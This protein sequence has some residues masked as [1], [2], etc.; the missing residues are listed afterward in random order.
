MEFKA[1]TQFTFVGSAFGVV[2]DEGAMP[3]PIFR[4]LSVILLIWFINCIGKITARHTAACDSSPTLSNN[5]ASIS[6]P[7]ECTAI[8]AV[9]VNSEDTVLRLAYRRNHVQETPFK[10]GDKARMLLK[11]LLSEAA[12]QDW[13]RGMQRLKFSDVEMTIN[14]E[15]TVAKMN[16]QAP[17][18]KQKFG[19]FFRAYWKH[20]HS[21]TM[22]CFDSTLTAMGG[23]ESAAEAAHSH[24]MAR[25]ARRRL[26]RNPVTHAFASNDTLSLLWDAEAIRNPEKIVKTER[27]RQIRI[28]RSLSHQHKLFL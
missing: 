9:S 7:Q 2:I 14:A 4:I 24:A 18:T 25:V 10:P 15:P 3:L 8:T 16:C 23:D 19:T 22:K 13:S 27:D 1:T 21:D 20:V 6:P 5:A 12:Q 11:Q 26:W 17:L 28:I